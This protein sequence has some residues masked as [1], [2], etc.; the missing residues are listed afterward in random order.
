MAREGVFG[1]VEPPELSPRARFALKVVRAIE[2]RSARQSEAVEAAFH[3]VGKVG[4]V[5]HQGRSV[6]RD[7]TG[8][9]RAGCGA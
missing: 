3:G 4:A 1:L 9:G 2:R 8:R 6:S 7:P 5:V